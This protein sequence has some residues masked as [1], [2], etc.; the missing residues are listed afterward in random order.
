MNRSMKTDSTDVMDNIRILL[1]PI[2]NRFDLKQRL[3]LLLNPSIVRLVKPSKQELEPR[4]TTMI[5]EREKSLLETIRTHLIDRRR[6]IQ[7]FC[8][9]RMFGVTRITRRDNNEDDR[10]NI[11]HFIP[12]TE[13]RE[14]F[15]R[16]QTALARRETNRLL[17][18]KNKR[19][20]NWDNNRI[21]LKTIHNTFH[22]RDKNY[23]NTE[24]QS[25]SYRGKFSILPLS[26]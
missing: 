15:L 18:T 7:S 14:L 26:I 23:T 22:H 10:L 4:R 1:I 20:T 9:S 21:D 11:F 2:D 16:Q 6:R 5:R 12:F 19:L 3:L 8:T 13:E 24:R 25:S 17:S